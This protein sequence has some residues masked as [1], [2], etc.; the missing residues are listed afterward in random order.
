M[1]F[2][3]ATEFGMDTEALIA[4]TQAAQQVAKPSTSAPVKAAAPTTAVVKAPDRTWLI[5]LLGAG[6]IGALVVFRK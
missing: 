3:G 4:R 6:A 5:A 2:L 1:A